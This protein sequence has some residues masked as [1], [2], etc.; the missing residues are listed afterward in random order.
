MSIDWEYL[1]DIAPEL[2]AIVAA[3]GVAVALVASSH[4][5]LNKRDTRAATAWVGLIWLVPVLGTLLYVFLGINRIERRAKVLREEATPYR[6]LPPHRSVRPRRKQ[7]RNAKLRLGP[8][9][10][11]LIFWPMPAVSS[12]IYVPMKTGSSRFPRTSF[13]GCRSCRS[14][15]VIR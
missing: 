6:R 11:T 8:S 2:S 5:I 14:S 3:F 15:S 7:G 9:R 10:P 1:R 13:K 4:V 12:P